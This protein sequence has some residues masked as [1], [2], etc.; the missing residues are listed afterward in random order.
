M[1]DI[2][3]SQLI[4]ECPLLAVKTPYLCNV[5]EENNMNRAPCCQLVSL[6]GCDAEAQFFFSSVVRNFSTGYFFLFYQY[7]V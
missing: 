4:Q 7:M 1:I 6:E 5:P 2:V 3:F